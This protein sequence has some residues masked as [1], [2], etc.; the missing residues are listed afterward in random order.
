MRVWL[1]MMLMALISLIGCADGQQGENHANPNTDNQTQPIHYETEKERN[2]RLNIREQSI[3]EKGGYP[4]SKQE[5]INES[6]FNSGYSDPFTNEEAI[7]ITEALQKKRQIVQAQVASTNDRILIGVILSTHV[8]GDIGNEI[9]KEVKKLLPDSNKEIIIYTDDTHWEKM[10][11]LDA[12][13]EAKDNGENM[14]E[15]INRF[16]K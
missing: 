12:R 6:N 11:N 8:S 14:E 7:M 2:E 9:K 15:L 1:G 10:R 16:L 5:N 4:Q 3:G 13:L